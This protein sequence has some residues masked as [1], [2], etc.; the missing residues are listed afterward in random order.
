M[1]IELIQKKKV[2]LILLLIFITI[3]P[4][5]FQ[6][7]G[8]RI[9]KKAEKSLVVMTPHNTTIQAEFGEA[10]TEYWQQKT[11]Q[12]VHV[13]WRRPGNAGEIKTIIEDN[14]R[15]ADR[16][17]ETGINVDV[18]FGGG[19][20]L[21]KQLAAA[22]RLVKLDV[23][24]QR[25]NWFDQKGIQP[26]FS[27]ERNYGKDLNWVGVCMSEFGICFNVE[28]L[29]RIGVES[30]K[31]WDDLAHRNYFGKI[32]LADPTKSGSTARAFEMLIQQ[33]IQVELANSVRR[34]GETAPA[35]RNRCIREGWA[36][37]LN[38]I[39]RIS[40]NA[41]YFTDSATKIPHGGLLW[42]YL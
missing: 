13:D 7:S 24:E 36:K 40:A 16:K 34:P 11:G 3:A 19:D 18:L 20:Y 27:G 28:G 32:A 38:L 9:S 25:K 12:I 33:K 21:F 5:L 31:T 1:F 26:V 10:F 17:N 6:H 22:D 41:R 39:K 23:F 14:F 15:R 29:K 35:L 42:P 30:P 2:Q 37:G 4:L 8:S